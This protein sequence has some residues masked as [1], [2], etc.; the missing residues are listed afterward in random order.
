M[1]SQHHQVTSAKK[2]GLAEAP[3]HEGTEPPPP[4]DG[5]TACQTAAIGRGW[6][7]SHAPAR[8]VPAH[9]PRHA[10]AAI[11]VSYRDYEHVYGAS[12]VY[13]P[14]CAADRGTVHDPS[15]ICLRHSQEGLLE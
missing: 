4:H 9:L 10:D 13:E 14:M 8:D 3:A 7:H 15:R 2:R 1:A 12:G 6:E 5:Q 11:G